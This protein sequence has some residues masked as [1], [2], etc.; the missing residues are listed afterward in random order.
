MGLA[1][2]SSLCAHDAVAAQYEIRPSITLSEEYDD[3]IFL[4]PNGKKGDFI[5]R[6]IPAFTL[7]HST[8]FW[9]W[10]I[11]YAYDYRYYSKKTV[12]GDTTYLANVVEHTNLYNNIF[13]IDMTDVYQRV[14]LDVTRNYSQESL[15][16]KQ[17]DQNIFTVSP[18]MNL[19]SGPSHTVQIGYQYGNSW[20]KDP[21]A[22]DTI[23]SAGFIAVN[24]PLSTNLA[25]MGDIRYTRG[26]NSLNGYFK[27]DIITGPV[28]SYAPGSAVFC[29]LGET[30]LRFVGYKNIHHLLWDLGF[31]HH[32]STMTLKVE[33]KTDYIPDPYNVLRRVDQL[34]ATLTREASTRTSLSGMAGWYEYRS[35]PTNY[36]ETTAYR[37]Q[38][39]MRHVLTVRSTFSGQ[40][41][42]EVLHDYSLDSDT[43]IYQIAASFERLML[44]D[45]TLTMNYIYTY[46][47]SPDIYSQN[48]RDNRFSVQLFKRF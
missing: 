38:G 29:K 25:V 27:T 6:V 39:S 41:S 23:D 48:S 44:P 9:T 46:A 11:A 21:A 17:S 28:Y 7:A 18:Y 3:N 5:S 34:E 37:V 2:L 22:V 19:L 15:S 36:L 8:S 16:F 45:L 33:T 30:W 4:T 32:Y 26:L 35:S 12:P 10:N 24:A 31:V 40:I 47:Y 43:F 42:N 14:S 20:Y 13:L 1:S